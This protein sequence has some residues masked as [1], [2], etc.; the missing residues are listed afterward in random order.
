MGEA[1]SATACTAGLSSGPA[2]ARSKPSMLPRT[3]LE[4]RFLPMDGVYSGEVTSL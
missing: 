4:D 1:G 2:A 3:P